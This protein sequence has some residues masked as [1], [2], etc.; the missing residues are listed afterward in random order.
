LLPIQDL[1]LDWK[2]PILQKNIAELILLSPDKAFVRL[3]KIYSPL[4]NIALEQ[5]NYVAFEGNIGAGKT[6]LA[7]KFLRILM[8]NSLERFGTILLPKFYKDQNR[9]AFPLEMSFWQIP[10]IIR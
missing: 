10:T 1:N 4:R 8:Q 5:F 2:H 7:T 3:F 6:T 9:Y